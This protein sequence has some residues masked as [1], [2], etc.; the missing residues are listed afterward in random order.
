MTALLMMYLSLILIITDRLIGSFI[1]DVSLI[2]LP[3][4]PP[5]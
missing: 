5:C 4:H 1:D 2:H 3:A